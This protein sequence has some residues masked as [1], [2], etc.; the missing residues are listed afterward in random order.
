MRLRFLAVLCLLAFSVALAETDPL[1]PSA[2][3][4]P[5]VPTLEKFLGHKLGGDFTPHH[6]LTAYYHALAA[7]SPR[8]KV[9][10]Y[11]KTAEGRPLNLVVITSPENHA[12][13]ADIRA[14]VAR[15]NDPRKTSQADADAIAASTPVIIYLSYGVHGNEASSA[16][17]AMQ[18]AYELAASQDAVNLERL[19]NA[20][21]L[22][23]PLVNPDGRERFVQGYRTVKGASPN[24]DRFAAEQ[25]ERW[26]SGRFNHYFF[27]LNRD[28]SWQ[29]QQ[30][31]RA[32][33]IAYRAWN[34][35]LHVDYHEMGAGSTYHFAPPAD[36][37]LES[38]NTPMLRKW[39]DIY[40]RANSQAF[41]RQGFRFFTKEDYDLFYPGFGD[42]WPLLNGA[43]GMTFEQGGGRAG[44][45]LE[46]PDNQRVL[47]LY[48]RALRHFVTSLATSDAT[49][50]NRVDRLKDYYA[51]RKAAITAGEQSP[52]RYAYIVASGD[53]ERAE[54]LV[55]VLLRQG[56]EV[57]RLA[58]DADA[59]RL[60]DYWGQKHAMRKIPAGSY[61]VD[62]AQPLGFLA[63][64]LLEREPKLEST[65]F[66]DVTAWSMPYASGVEA[67]LGGAGAKADLRPVTAP[68]V[69]KG[70]VEGGQEVAAYV[71][72]SEP[73]ASVRLLAALLQADIRVYTS[74]RGFKQ[75]GR[76]FPVGSLII[77]IETNPPQLG[78]KVREL[79]E[80]TGA[81]VYAVSSGRS[82]SGVDLGSNRVRFLRKPKI[83]IVMDSPVSPSEYG[84]IW[85]AFEQQY[86]VPFTPIKAENLG[87][88]DLNSY[89][90]IILPP[91][92]GDGRGY[93]RVMGGLGS[94][95]ADWVRNGGVLV[96]IRGGALFAAKK[97]SGITSVNF[98]F[99]S[100]A[101]EE[102]RIEEERS[103]PK[104]DEAPSA[105]PPPPPS[106]KEEQ[107]K[108]R[109]ARLERKL[110]KYADKEKE[111]QKEQVPGAILKTNLDNTHPLAYG[112]GD[113]LAVLNNDA[114]I[115]E[116]TD[117][118]DNVAYFPKEGIKLSGFITPENEK[119]LG[120]T[121]YA[122]RERVG[123]GFVIMFAD[124][125]VFRGFWDSTDR[126]LLNAIYFGRVTIPGVE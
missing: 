26:P 74:T 59:P 116:L 55:N 9:E 30:E 8:V 47:T 81:T 88:A 35:Q 34:P 45:A 17:A 107:E 58:A 32:R 97:R 106:S 43:I 99:L 14:A 37:I 111:L 95:L 25:S 117:K 104:R 21:I 112:M 68:V 101:S 19:Q 78:A 44:L 5:A 15:L 79:A 124:N 7:A 49:I 69:R 20:V 67:Y 40:G 87:G 100:R 62:M 66:Y 94:R 27:D 121:A 98:K 126:L 56:I 42:S 73:I 39:F 61:V 18:V 113:Q 10:P 38:L 64:A 93:Q 110:R 16:E 4:D 13:I 3:Y 23:D 65:F 28:W 63:R 103:A 84:Y 51:F 89:N 46:L 122:L 70:S 86:G 102:A 1:S 82:E 48:D 31:T 6:Q 119:K 85:H 77:P 108:E 12:R 2:K 114:P 75:A 123:R 80:K 72:S 115:L 52:E 71:F 125:P 105:E 11:G 90:V 24:P 36:P 60:T 57:H 41:D 92:S 96:G 29:S 76:D 54:K 120:H 83:A 118:G 53:A 109:A 33:V 22:I 50:K 91:D